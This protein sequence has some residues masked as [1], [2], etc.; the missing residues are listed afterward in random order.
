VKLESTIKR[1]DLKFTPELSAH[2]V[3]LCVFKVPIQAIRAVNELVRTLAA[4]KA[5]LNGQA[6][7]DLA[8]EAQT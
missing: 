8:Q 6:S 5:R 3:L 1:I 4:V 2:F 7:A